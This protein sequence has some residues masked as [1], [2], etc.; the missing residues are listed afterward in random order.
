MYPIPGLAGG[1]PPPMTGWGTPPRPEMGYLPPDLRW[2]TPYLRWGTPHPDL[3]WGTPPT[4]G[5]PPPVAL[6]TRRVDFLVIIIINWPKR[7]SWR[8]QMIIRVV[9]LLA[10]LWDQGPPMLV[11]I[12]ASTAAM[13]TTRVAPEMNPRNSLHTGKK[14]DMPGIH[15]GFETQGKKPK[16]APQR[17]FVSSKNYKKTFF[18]ISCTYNLKS[19]C[20]S[21]FSSSEIELNSSF[22]IIVAT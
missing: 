11:D 5:K 7:P 14:A 10:L 16:T 13:P 1:V 6:A 20:F 3:R 18:K 22:S 8:G 2:G 17:G 19:I 12:L 4:R 21:L 9:L 15:S